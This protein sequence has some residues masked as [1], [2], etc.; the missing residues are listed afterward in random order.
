MTTGYHS[1]ASNARLSGQ[2]FLHANSIYGEPIQ[3]SHIRQSTKA[4]PNGQLRSPNSYSGA[5]ASTPIE[6]DIQGSTFATS[7]SPS[8]CFILSRSLWCPACKWESI[9]ER[10]TQSANP[11][12]GDACRI[13]TDECEELSNVGSPGVYRYVGFDGMDPAGVGNRY[14]VGHGLKCNV[15]HFVNNRL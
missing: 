9:F 14:P 10:F 11:G 3:A 2:L 15:G 6:S 12:S 7:T 4:N 8:A 13:V 5:S 1:I